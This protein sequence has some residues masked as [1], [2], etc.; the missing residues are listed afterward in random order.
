MSIEKITDITIRL[1]PR[2]SDDAFASG[3]TV[4]LA[5]GVAEGVRQAASDMREMIERGRT[6]E[7]VYERLVEEADRIDAG[8]WT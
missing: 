8:I 2:I 7:E 5:R 3:W 4:G 6:P 1:K